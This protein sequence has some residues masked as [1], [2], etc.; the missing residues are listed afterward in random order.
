[1]H[2]RLTLARRTLTLARARQCVPEP[3]YGRL[4]SGHVAGPDGQGS[5]RRSSK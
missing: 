2:A 3:D 5:S 1:M 4:S